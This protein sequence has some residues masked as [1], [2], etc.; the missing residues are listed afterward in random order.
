[1]KT[2]KAIKKSVS[3]VIF[4]QDRSKILLVQRP[5][6]PGERWPKMWSLPSG[7]VKAGESYKEATIRAGKEKLGVKVDIVRFLGKGS[8]DRGDYITYLKE[9]EVRIKSGIPSCPQPIKGITQYSKWK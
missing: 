2:P 6:N 8:A 1:M 9:F 3:L 4:N 5:D 7:S